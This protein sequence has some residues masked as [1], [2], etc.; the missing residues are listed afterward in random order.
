MKKRYLIKDFLK[1]FKR[2]VQ[3]IPDKDYKLV[4]I[5][6]KHRGIKLRELKKGSLI[7][8][9]M[10]EVKA[11]DFV[12][13]GIDARNGAFGI[14]PQELDGGIITND[15]W[16][17]QI[18]ENV[19][20]KELFL[21]LTAT[22]WFDDLCNRGSDG[23]TN[24]VRLQKDKFF[25]QEVP[26]PLKN[27]QKHLLHKILS[28]KQKSVTLTQEIENQKKL[29]SQFK[30]ATLEEA[31]QGKLTEKWRVENPDIEVASQL[32][33]RIKAEKSQLI[34]EK[35][36]KKEKDLVTIS[37]EEIPFEIPE[38]WVWCRLGDIGLINPKNN[39]KQNIESSFI[40]M[41]FISDHYG[42]IPIYESRQWND[43]KKGYTH[44]A[45]NDI[46]FAKITPCFENSKA[47][48]FKNLKN[49][50]GAGTT[51]LHI[52]RCLPENKVICNFIYA[53]FKSTDFLKNGAAVMTG[54]AG[55]KRVPKEYLLNKI[56]P[57]PPFDEQQAIV[58]KIEN[59]MAQCAILEKK[60]AQ[61]EQ[62]AKML[63]KAVL[64]EAFENKERKDVDEVQMDRSLQLALM[65]IMFKQKLG[66]NYGEVIMQKTA[67][68]L[69]HLYR[70]QSSFFP[71][72][73]QSCNHGAFSVQL[74]EEI[75]TNPYLTT[76]SAEKGNV[77]CVDPEQNSTVLAAF[78]N[79]VYTDY[80]HSLTQLLEIYSLP[81]IGKKSEQIELFNTVLKIVNDLNITDINTIYSTM[82]KW[83]IEQKGFKTKAEKFSKL[84][85]EKILL[86][87][88]NLQLT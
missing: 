75:E 66:I 2:P 82:E 31:L 56:I 1:R 78:S 88:K 57:L 64:K 3:L 87:I 6:S 50:I 32:L 74:R 38:N 30:Q 7:K 26:L 71:Y 37:K 18:N 23:T 13:S 46:G 20:S 62:N 45:E 73:F 63:M 70:K 28:I 24:R 54:S 33:K 52:F 86:F 65:Q 43:I 17:L 36:L 35:K 68:N 79:P 21:E 47:A 22:T 80:I 10:Y 15:F 61:S 42:V 8:S 77:I 14:I 69:D 12:L 83:E 58:E 16:C 29:L 76:K 85:T 72:S 51:E 11:G 9:N 48:V 41:E 60:I 40:P 81:I 55:Q 19:I 34:N 39:E 67:Y 59:I 44:F 4:T 5:S 53:I 25:S 27:E 49:N 84:Q